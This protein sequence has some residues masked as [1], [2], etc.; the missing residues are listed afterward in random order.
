VDNAILTTSTT[1]RVAYYV[2]IYSQNDNENT[3]STYAGIRAHITL[4]VNS[5]N[6]Q[7]Y[8]TNY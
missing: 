7:N 3:L 5:S 1:Y 2:T 6:F 8:F 4:S